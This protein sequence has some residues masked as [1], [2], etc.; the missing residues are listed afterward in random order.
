[1]VKLIIGAFMKKITPYFILAVVVICI[2][3]DFGIIAYQGKTES[4]SATLIR[5]YYEYPSMSFISG[6]LFGHLTWKMKDKDVWGK[7]SK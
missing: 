2:A 4:I 5:W 3:Y 1:M 7:E 6:Y